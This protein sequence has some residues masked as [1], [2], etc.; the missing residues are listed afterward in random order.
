MK[1]GIDTLGLDHGQSGLGSYLFYLMKNLS[2]N[3]QIQYSLFGQEDDRYTYKANF[4]TEY[5]AVDVSDSI[6]AQRW[7]HRFD[8]ARFVRQQKYDVVFYCAASRMFP[9]KTGVKGIAVINDIVSKLVEDEGDRYLSCKG[10]KYLRNACRI[11]VPTQFVK[12]DLV[13]YGF[14]G[15]K[16]CVIP[17]GIDHNLFY[18]QNLS[19]SEYVDI[20]PFAIKR[21]YIIYPTRISGADKNHIQLI[22]A[23]NQFKKKTN[24]AHRLVLA[25]DHDSYAEQVQKEI[26]ASPYASDIFLTGFFPHKELGPLYSNA[27][28]CIF[29]SAREG[30]GLPVLEMMAC[31]VPV[32]CSCKGAL[33]E[34]SGN[35]AVFFDPDNIDQIADSLEKILSDTN[36]RQNLIQN[37]QKWAASFTWKNTA[38]K[39]EN[40][41]AE[42]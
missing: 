1:I 3:D 20:K 42:L 9:K 25:G 21:P 7:W 37:G 28:A 15:D 14:S 29:P 8:C 23:F 32:A 26:L 40:L 5:N 6:K 12:N 35:N 39:I 4:D 24:L 34:V 33:P 17:N 27:D 18:P 13:Q 19:D 31:G 30:V 10:L 22:R 11:I 36:L 41:I 2:P 16:I 38:L